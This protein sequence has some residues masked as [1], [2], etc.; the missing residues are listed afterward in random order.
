MAALA[1][2][3]L[4]NAHGAPPQPPAGGPQAAI[5]KNLAERLPQLP[6]IE[7]ITATGIPGLYEVRLAGAEIVYTDAQG[8][9]LL[10]GQLFDTQQRRNLTKERIDKLTAIDFGALP[11]KDAFKLVRGNGQRKLAVF[12]DP[13]CGYCKRFERDLESIDNVTVYLFL[14]PVLG[15]DSVKKSQHIWC[16]KSPAETW[17]NWMVR[18]QPIPAADCD[19][20]AVTRNVAL[21]RKHKINGTPTLLFADGT[22]VPGAVPASEVEKRLV[23]A[24][25]PAKP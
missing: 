24:S 17:S 19:A 8:D 22:R 6:A 14:Y 25:A 3:A 23:A 15:A 18:G 7:E 16:A 12:A 4:A 2:A 9:F 20:A 10:Q 13:N 1:L 11:L 21:G 5:R